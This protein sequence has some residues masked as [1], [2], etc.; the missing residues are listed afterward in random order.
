MHSKQASSIHY[1]WPSRNIVLRVNVTDM[2]RQSTRGS[3]AK[4]DYTAFQVKFSI[5]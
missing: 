4:L 2:V 1:S 3:S 5:S